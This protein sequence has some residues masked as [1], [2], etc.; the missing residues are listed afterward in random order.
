MR[1]TA[2]AHVRAARSR[3]RMTTLATSLLTALACTM[4]TEVPA[5]SDYILAK[6][7][8]AAWVT[9]RDRI[10]HVD[11]PRVSDDSIVGMNAGR[12]FKAW[13]GNVRE[14]TVRQIDW[15]ATDA[16]VATVSVVTVFGVMSYVDR[17]KGGTPLPCGNGPDLTLTE[18]VNPQ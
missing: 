17:P 6:H 14:V 8:K 7:P 11:D 1:C 9:S 13:L 4:Q 15:P 2:G 10:S 5:P 16:L 12:S 18:C 3:V